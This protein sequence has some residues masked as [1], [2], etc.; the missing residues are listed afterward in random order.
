MDKFKSKNMLLSVIHNLTNGVLA[1]NPIPGEKRASSKRVKY[2]ERGYSKF[3][4]VFLVSALNGDGV[5]DIKVIY[6]KFLFPGGIGLSGFI[7]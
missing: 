2:I 4:D 3:S 6:Y 5:T 1:G 7:P